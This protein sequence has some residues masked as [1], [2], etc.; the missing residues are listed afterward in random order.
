MAGQWHLEP[1][2][3]LAM[4]RSEVPAYDALQ[5]ALA[6]ASA[7]VPARSILD[8]GSGTGVTAQAVLA[9]HPDAALLGLDASP[10]MLAHARRLVP[11]ATFAV[12]RLEDPLPEGPFDLVVSAFAIHHLDGPGK[13]SL[14]ERIAAVLAPGGRFVLC[15]VVVP[16][17]PVARPVPLEAGV[18][19]PSSVAD[20][21]RWLT[22]AGLRPRVVHAED[23]LAVIAAD[24]GER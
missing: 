1:D 13:A 11:G 5:A 14:F 19:L 12:H 24:A 6:D 20:Q 9:R 21:L 7:A 16:E 15:D 10:D 4:I 18:D 22:G 17:H 8:L 23:D 2:T 3:Y